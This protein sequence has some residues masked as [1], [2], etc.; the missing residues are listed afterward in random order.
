[1]S[2]GHVRLYH[3]FS[4]ELVFELQLVKKRYPHLVFYMVRLEVNLKDQFPSI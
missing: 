3:T 2:V 4:R 1:M